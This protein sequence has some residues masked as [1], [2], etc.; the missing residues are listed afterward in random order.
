MLWYEFLV[1]F[2]KGEK[3]QMD[4][5]KLIVGIVLLGASLVFAHLLL[6]ECSH[7]EKII[8]GAL[9]GAANGAYIGSAVAAPAGAIAGAAIGAAVGAL[10]AKEYKFGHHSS[11]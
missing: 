3:M 7:K 11:K 5:S 1:F 10:V 2:E 8:A 9:I 6:R 4:T